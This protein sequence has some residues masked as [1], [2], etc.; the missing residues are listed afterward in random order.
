VWP[1]FVVVAPP[2]LQQGASV[3][4]RA[5]QGLVEQFVAQAAVEAF[6]EAILLRLAGG[7]VM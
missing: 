6:D 4:Q 7:D 5:E 1:F 2:R 3:R